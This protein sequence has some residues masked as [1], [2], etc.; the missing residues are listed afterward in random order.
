MYDIGIVTLVNTLSSNTK[1]PL[2][3]HLN[4]IIVIRDFKTGPR[5]LT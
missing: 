2:L 5:F 1:K 4:K 3:C